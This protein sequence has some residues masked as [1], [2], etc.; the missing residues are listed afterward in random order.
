[1]IILTQE[2]YFVKL[3]NY[4]R[5]YLVYSFYRFKDDKIHQIYD[6]LH[7]QL[8]KAF[9]VNENYYIEIMTISNSLNDYGKNL[10]KNYYN[11]ELCDFFS[12]YGRIWNKQCK[13]VADNIAMYGLWF[14]FNHEVQ[15]LIFLVK[16]TDQLIEIGE[17]KGYYYDE[18][19][20]DS[21]IVN[22][23]YPQN[24]SLHQDYLKY[25][26]FDMINSNSTLNLTVLMENI[27]KPAIDGL[28]EDITNEMKNLCDSVEQYSL[29][30]CVWS[31]I[32][33]TISYIIIFIPKI[34][35]TDSQIKQGKAMLKIIPKEERD[36]I[37][38]TLKKKKSE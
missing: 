8:T 17:S 11:D 23:L 30:L 1:M 24:E 18:I 33:L 14:A 21:G 6:S 12:D 20:Y 29:V 2:T 19:L 38:K 4:Y 9:E 7:E 16:R 10:F 25:N 22:E 35:K 34:I 28:R 15:L 13:E 5:T 31:I 27:V 3:F 32:I 37:K 36:K 26:P